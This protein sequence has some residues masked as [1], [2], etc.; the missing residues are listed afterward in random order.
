MPIYYNLGNGKEK[1]GN[2]KFNLGNGTEKSSRIVGN[3]GSG[4]EVYFISGTERLFGYSHGSIFE[5]YDIDTLHRIN[6]IHDMYHRNYGGTRQRLFGSAGSTAVEFNFDTGEDIN[7]LGIGITIN[8]FG[9]T[10]NNLYMTDW[11]KNLYLV[12]K[13]T[14]N[15]SFLKYYSA[16]PSIQSIGGI[17]NKLYMSYLDASYNNYMAEIDLTSYEL[18]SPVLITGTRY[19]YIGGINDRLYATYSDSYNDDNWLYEISTSDYSILN[20]Y[21]LGADK[22]LYGLGGIKI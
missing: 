10:A 6:I 2:G 1:L 15:V 13:D 7:S 20:A 9:G 22:R 3:L 21:E 11:D 18:I 14:L 5:E 16:I 17:L 4:T 8:S 19:D 12:N